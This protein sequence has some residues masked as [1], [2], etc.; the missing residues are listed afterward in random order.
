MLGAA[1]ILDVAQGLAWLQRV[2]VL[3]GAH[4]L[5]VETMESNMCPFILFWTL[6]SGSPVMAPLGLRVA[7]SQRIK[8]RIRAAWCLPSQCPLSPCRM[9]AT[10]LPDHCCL[11]ASPGHAR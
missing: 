6:G 2:W 7:P 10:L 9:L 8:T 5:Q 11:S 3:L 4:C 1:C